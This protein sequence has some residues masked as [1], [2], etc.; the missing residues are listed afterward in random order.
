MGVSWGEKFS[1]TQNKNKIYWAKTL[2]AMGVNLIIG[3]NP[4]LVQPVS[5]VKADNGNYALVFFSLGALVG[6]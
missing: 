5:F 6:S 4:A 1:L 2:A 3:K